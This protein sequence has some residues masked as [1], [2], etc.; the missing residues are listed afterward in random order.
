MNNFGYFSLVH[1]GSD[2]ALTVELHK[3]YAG[4]GFSLEGGN[5]SSHGDAPLTFK[6]IFR[7]EFE[8]I[9]FLCLEAKNSTVS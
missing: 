5:A 7:G 8:L 9:I 3:T 6:R 4:L 2:D 1:T